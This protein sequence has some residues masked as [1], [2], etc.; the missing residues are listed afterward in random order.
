[1]NEKVFKGKLIA[2][3][4]DIFNYT[5]YVFE[6][7]EYDDIDYQYIMCVRFPNWQ[8]NNIELNSIGF[9]RVKYVIS[10]EDC[11]FDGVNKIPYKQTNVI[12]INFIK[13]S[14]SLDQIIID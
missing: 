12:F 9:V 5:T 8:V 2:F 6:N 4:T 11:W 14:T 7:L 10:G 13:E 1:M 3:N